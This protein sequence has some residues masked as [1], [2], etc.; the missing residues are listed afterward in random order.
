MVTADSGL[1]GRVLT[2]IKW[3]P[4]VDAAEIGVT[5]DEHVITLHGH[6]KSYTEKLA[7]A[8]AARRVFGVQGIANEIE[9]KPFPGHGRTDSDIAESAVTAL[10]WSMSVPTNAVK[11]TVT[12]GRVRLDGSVEWQFERR[13]AENAV[14]DL[15]GVTGVTNEVK[16]TP[17]ASEKDV[18][19]KIEGAFQRNAV[20]L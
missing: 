16:I 1:Q 9:V 19:R 7:A 17:R 15:Y 8:R 20:T 18:K 13:A 14:R 2:E 4:S 5:A 3:E 12:N 6:V 11:A 10:S